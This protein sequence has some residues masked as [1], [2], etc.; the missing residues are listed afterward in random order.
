MTELVRKAG[1]TRTQR[2][3]SEKLEYARAS[4]QNGGGAQFG[5]KPALLSARSSPD[6]GGSYREVAT[7]SKDRA[8]S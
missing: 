4:S 3:T 6:Y 8:T 1:N 7:L 5:Q 2:R